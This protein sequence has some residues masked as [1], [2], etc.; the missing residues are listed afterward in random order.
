MKLLKILDLVTQTDKGPFLKILDSLS[1]VSRKNIPKIEEIIT[2]ADG[3]LKNAENEAIVVLFDCLKP[4]YKDLLHNRIKFSNCQLDILADILMRDGNSKMTREWFSR[5]YQEE[6]RKLKSDIKQ[7]EEKLKEGKDKGDQNRLRDYL[8]FRSCVKTAYENDLIENRDARISRDEL[9]IIHALAQG[10]ELSNQ[11]IRWITYSVVPLEIIGIDEL[12]RELK[13]AG[14]IFY[15]KKIYTLYTP[16]EIIWLLQ[17]I[18]NIEIPNKYLRRILR[19]LS[20]SEINLVAKK[21]GI[22]NKLKRKQ[23]AD[24]LLKQGLDAINLLTQEI[25]K[26]GSTKTER[27]ERLHKLISKDLDIQLSKFGR[28]IEERVKYLIQYFNDLE[29]D[30]KSSLTEDGYNKLLLDLSTHFLNVNMVLKE[31]FQLQEENVLEA[32]VLDIYNIKPRDV[33]YLF[34]REELKGFCRKRNLRLSG[35]LA[36]NIIDNYRVIEDLLID[37]FNLVGSRDINGLHKKGLTLKEGELGIVYENLTKRIFEKFGF[38]VD[39][40]LRKQLNTKRHQ[41]DII[42]NI[43]NDEV[44]IIECKTIKEG[45]YSKYT[46]VS[47][48]LKSYQKLCKESGYRVIQALIVSSEFTKDFIGDCEYDHELNLSLIT[49]R[50]LIKVLEIYKKSKFGEFPVRLLQKD[51]LLD[52]DRICKVLKK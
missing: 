46:S 32:E 23:K 11:E 2:S 39:E 20:D 4:P 29:K 36:S 52:E 49:S 3:Q 10:L 24:D 12:I 33:L 25:F 21:H 35:N 26:H 38:N 27:A 19:H 30:V 47:R 50:G 28:S 15:S 22:E 5:L 6:I 45:E 14:I 1:D 37:N 42:L 44:I 9:I 16:D 48:Q 40:T 34:S 41:I 17:E 8:I 51:G 7:F 13:D 43:G 18:N 31:E